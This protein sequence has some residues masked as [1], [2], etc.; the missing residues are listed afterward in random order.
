LQKIL[1]SGKE[2]GL[3]L[4][5]KITLVTEGFGTAKYCELILR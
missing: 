4:D 2:D 3:E 1:A 5:R